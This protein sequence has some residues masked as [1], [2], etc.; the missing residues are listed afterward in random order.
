MNIK[1]TLAIVL[2]AIMIFSLFPAASFAYEQKAPYILYGTSDTDS[3]AVE[4]YDD[5][6]GTY[7]ALE[8]YDGEC[9][10]I[11]L[12]HQYDD[13]TDINNER[14]VTLRLYG[15]NVIHVTEPCMFD[16]D[17][18]LCGIVCTNGTF[19]GSR[20]LGNVKLEGYDGATLT[21]VN[22]RGN[23]EP[24]E[25][26]VGLLGILANNITIE[27]LDVKVVFKT[28]R[29]NI[30]KVTMTSGIYSEGTVNTLGTTSLDID[31]D[32]FSESETAVGI[33]S[34][35][36]EDNGKKYGALIQSTGDININVLSTGA[37]NCMSY[38]LNVKID[39]TAGRYIPDIYLATNPGGALHSLSGDTKNKEPAFFSDGSV[40]EYGFA[41]GDTYCAI[42]RD[43]H[44]ERQTVNADDVTKAFPKIVNGGEVETRFEGETFTGFIT[45]YRGSQNAGALIK[46]YDEIKDGSFCYV[47]LVPKPGYTF[48]GVKANAYIVPGAAV[49]NSADSGYFTAT[50][51]KKNV[52]NKDLS[53]SIECGGVKQK[54][55]G[56]A[57]V[58][59]VG[60]QTVTASAAFGGTY[61][62]EPQ[63]KWYLETCHQEKT[64][65]GN[66]VVTE[67]KKEIGTGKTVSFKSEYKT[68]KFYYIFAEI[69][70]FMD[71]VFSSRKI[72]INTKTAVPTITKQP[73]SVYA[74]KNS[75]M[76][77]E[78]EANGGELN[79]QWKYED[80]RGYT[81]DFKDSEYVS[82][83]NTNSLT[84]TPSGAHDTCR[85]WCE[86]SNAQGKANSNRVDCVVYESI[87]IVKDLPTTVY[88]VPGDD[89]T[90]EVEA[91]SPNNNKDLHYEW[92]FENYNSHMSGGISLFRS[93]QTGT[94]IEDGGKLTIKNITWDEMNQ[95][96]FYCY[97]GVAAQAPL[98]SKRVRFAKP[99]NYVSDIEI[100]GVT[101]PVVGENADFNCPVPTGKGYSIK[102][103]AVW[104]D[105]SGNELAKDSIFA[106]GEKYTFSATLKT[107]DNTS[108]NDDCTATVNGKKAK[109]VSID[110]KSN[111]VTVRYTFTAVEKPEFVYALSGKTVGVG[112]TVT[113]AVKVRNPSGVTYRWFKDDTL[114]NGA[115]GSEYSFEVSAGD[116]GVNIFC[117]ASNEA[118]EAL[119]EQ[120]TLT[121]KQKLLLGNIESHGTGDSVS[122][123]DARLVL[124]AAVK[125]DTLTGVDL[126]L[127]DIDGGGVSVSDAR[128]VL[129]MAVRLDPLQYTDEY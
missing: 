99:E 29:D 52:V 91:V 80:D 28:N 69:T 23:T 60:G 32:I 22:E 98:K 71:T 64:T 82:G 84:Y 67:S 2:S 107:D 1:R 123:A 66:T 58:E 97:V 68:G 83:A 48:N 72:R 63:V 35:S 19:N 65:K 8:G 6:T 31:F 89:V 96:E 33:S 116:N 24:A 122:V 20:R 30:D 86:V 57:E 9:I 108:F 40:S 77:F 26:I 53:V 120:A 3:H 114:V 36:A 39:R 56:T 34:E 74:G 87:A 112:K 43:R 110:G 124:R 27:N 127:A 125:L 92:V 54:D 101:V 73:E 88:V 115:T 51:Y 106:A 41:E 49:R 102:G 79:Y 103:S 44:T 5:V 7:V 129:R 121:V 94:V 45:W 47:S 17:Y 21:I 100:N 59:I 61:S 111:E 14:S 126:V 4:Y 10:E 50:F 90:L 11:D 55:I 42:D 25:D 95:F 13:K 128:L 85:V 38:P 12:A 70:P 37:A 46:T 93:G 16:F 15:D 109:V 105:A 62:V 118:G 119:S 81:G 104:T 117:I 76:H 78:V 75:Q 18:S 113:F